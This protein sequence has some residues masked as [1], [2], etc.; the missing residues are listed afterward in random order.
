MQIG[1]NNISS[2]TIIE[3]VLEIRG[4]MTGRY[5][6]TPENSCWRRVGTEYDH[7]LKAFLLTDF[8]TIHN[9][10]TNKYLF[11]GTYSTPHINKNLGHGRMPDNWDV[12]GNEAMRT[13]ILPLAGLLFCKI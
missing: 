13:I 11:P 8:W 5:H 12:R 2:L 3:S 7:V 9:P 4:R 10:W 6:G 1:D